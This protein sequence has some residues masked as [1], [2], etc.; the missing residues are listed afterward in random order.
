MIIIETTDS[1]V[2]EA[3][4]RLIAIDQNPETTLLAI[5]EAVLL[6]LTKQRFETSTDPYGVPW[7]QNSDTTLRSALH[8]SAKNF[9]KAGKLSKRGNAVL[10]GK[11]PL[12]GESKSLSTQFAYTVIGSDMVTLTSL[13]KYAA[14]QNFGGSKAEFPHLWGDIPARQFFPDEVRGLPTDYAQG[15]T[16]VLVTALQ[17]AWDGKP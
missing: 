6:P 8:G 3:F 10:A 17:S 4:N 9:T 16:G 14:M 13:M 15:I 5:G 7:E 2:L 1:G 11:K 12:I